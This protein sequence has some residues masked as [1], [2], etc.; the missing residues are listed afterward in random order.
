MVV[1]ED[2]STHAIRA[3]YTDS[4]R[5]TIQYAV[6]IAGD[7]KRLVFVSNADGQHQ[8]FRFTYVRLDDGRMT[9]GPE[10]APADHPDQFRKTVESLVRRTS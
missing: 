3:F 7:R 5:N 6:T 2:A 10:T 8:R 9:V 4:E 1:D